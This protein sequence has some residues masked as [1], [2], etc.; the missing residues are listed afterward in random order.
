MPYDDDSELDGDDDVPPPS[1]DGEGDDQ[2]ND[3]IERV[4]VKVR[5]RVRGKRFVPNKAVLPILPRMRVRGKTSPQA[6][7]KQFCV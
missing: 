6:L 3:T 7:G 1:D 5:F 4:P 2:T